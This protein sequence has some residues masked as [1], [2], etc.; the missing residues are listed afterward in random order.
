MSG[1]FNNPPKIPFL[2]VGIWAGFVDQSGFVDQLSVRR[3]G[4]VDQSGFVDQLSV[5]RA[6]F[7]DQLSVTS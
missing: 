2:N 3:A 1:K 5:R 4:F 7:V 6:G